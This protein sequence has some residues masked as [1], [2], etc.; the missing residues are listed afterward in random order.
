MT[1]AEL[2][3]GDAAVHGE[4]AYAAPE[5]PESAPALVGASVCADDGPDDPFLDA[6][7]ALIE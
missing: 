6:E 3:V 1:D 2:E 7:E 5:L 4:V